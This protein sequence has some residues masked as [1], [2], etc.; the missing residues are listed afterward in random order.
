MNFICLPLLKQF[1]GFET[2][3][4]LDGAFPR[5][6]VAEPRELGVFIALKDGLFAGLLHTFQ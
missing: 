1:S 2:A 4:A 3:Q 5:P 6:F